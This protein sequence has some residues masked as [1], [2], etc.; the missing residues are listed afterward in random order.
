ML[1]LR[2]WHGEELAGARDRTLTP[3]QRQ[4]AMQRL[5]ESSEHPCRV[6]HLKAFTQFGN[7]AAEKFDELV[8]F[9]FRPAL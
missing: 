4:E 8:A 1:N 2:L 6:K 9:Y 5:A 7:C 3:H